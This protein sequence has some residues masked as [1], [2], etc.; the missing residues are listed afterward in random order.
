MVLYE[1]CKQFTTSTTQ[2]LTI[3]EW[4][5]PFEEGISN[6]KLKTRFP[7]T[8]KIQTNYPKWKWLAAITALKNDKISMDLKFYGCVQLAKRLAFFEVHSCALVKLIFVQHINARLKCCKNERM[9]KFRLRWR[10]W[11][12]A[13]ATNC[14]LQQFHISVIRLWSVHRNV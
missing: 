10:Q 3:F 8:L 9:C 13:K 2:Y 6:F 11:T 4:H 5:F 1:C 14:M 7:V 12:F